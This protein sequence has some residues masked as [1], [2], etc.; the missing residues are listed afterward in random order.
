MER[1]PEGESSLALM[2]PT[3]LQNA[4]SADFTP[5]QAAPAIDSCAI[6]SFSSVPTI[7]LFFFFTP[8]VGSE[9]SH[10]AQVLLA[11]GLHGYYPAL[12]RSDQVLWLHTLTTLS[13]LCVLFFMSILQLSFSLCL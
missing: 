5:H 2:S 6:A 7:A 3:V 13:F 9:S 1:S 8:Q 4:A 10:D 11:A 12:P